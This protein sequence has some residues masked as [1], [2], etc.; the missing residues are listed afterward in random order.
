M[1][2]RIPCKD[3]LFLSH[4]EY[5]QFKAWICCYTNGYY[6]YFM[7]TEE[8]GLSFETVGYRFQRANRKR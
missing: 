7:P 6:E 2:F 5:I 3:I 1:S 8:Y 4:M